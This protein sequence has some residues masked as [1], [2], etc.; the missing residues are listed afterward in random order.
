MRCCGIGTNFMT[1]NR[2]FKWV[3]EIE[4]DGTYSPIRPLTTGDREMLARNILR[5]SKS[6]W[7][8][9]N[10]QNETIEIEIENHLNNLSYYKSKK[11][12]IFPNQAAEIPPSCRR[13]REAP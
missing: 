1:S 2:N 10:H 9:L 3:A 13:M 6:I 5:K 4:I 8:H 12:A 11:C 7:Q